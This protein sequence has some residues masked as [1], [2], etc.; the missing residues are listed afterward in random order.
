VAQLRAASVATTSGVAASEVT[1][2]VGGVLKVLGGNAEVLGQSSDGVLFGQAAADFGSNG[3][4]VVWSGVSA[5]PQVVSVTGGKDLVFTDVNSTGLA[6]GIGLADD[7][8]DNGLAW[9]RRANGTTG[10]LNA[11]GSAKAVARSVDEDGRVAGFLMKDGVAVPVVWDSVTAAPR[12]LALA[13]GDTGGV[14]TA[15]AGGAVAGATRDDRLA[16]WDPSGTVSAS[17]EDGEA[18]D[19]N[20]SGMVL[21]GS[22]SKTGVAPRVQLADGTVVDL[23]DA[24]DAAGRAKRA[25]AVSAAGAVVGSY[26]DRPVLWP[27]PGQAPM[28]LPLPEG[29]TAGR[30]LGFGSGHRVLGW[31][32]TATGR[33]PVVWGLTDVVTPP[34]TTPP[35]TTAPPTT[36]PPSSEPSTPAPTSAPTTA[37]P[38][39]TV[40]VAVR[41]VGGGSKVFVDVDP[42]MGKRYWTFKV[43]YRKK[44]GTWGQYKK[45]YKTSG[46]K[47]TRTLNFKKGT[48]RV[49]V[50]P[51]YGYQGTTSTEVTLRK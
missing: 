44:N 3:Q 7:G 10:L 11:D 19:M 16:R 21:F 49:A 50:N 31:A 1:A 34:P 15:A 6:V 39:P 45:T 37:P 8:S 36:P 14:G 41:A 42:N 32:Q 27:A 17:V 51:K 24:G 4:P 25:T 38:V 12:Y 47:E 26:G 28:Y 35:P 20:A 29:A 43:Q 48:Y 30:A 23:P 22:A 2:E 33:V 18:V 13:A 5:E 40:S 46:S 9:F